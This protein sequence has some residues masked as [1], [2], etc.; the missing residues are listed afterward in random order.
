MASASVP[1]PQQP[2]PSVSSFGRVFG[3]LFN[4]KPTFESIVQQPSWILPMLAVVLISI[5]IVA[6]IGSR[7]G[8]RQVI[9]RQI[10]SSP[11]AQQRME[12]VPAGQREEILD[13]QAKFAGIIAYVGVVLGTVIAEVV[14]A[15][16]LM[17]VFNLMAG[18]KTGFST[19]LGIVA[20]SWMPY[21]V[22]GIL[23]IVIL[24]IK[25][26]STVDIEH[27]VAS[28]P[29]AFLPDTAPKWL[30]SLATSFD[31]FTIW[32]LILQ[33]IGFSAT[34]PK[35]ISVGRAFGIIFAVFLI[36]VL[37]KAGLAAAFS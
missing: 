27:L 35:K 13:K 3:A 33:A 14:A 9:D 30:V 7:V 15:A 29:G 12:Q 1:P 26:P 28:N 22:A 17:G 19:A 37:I 21:F 4:P 8:W 25:D 24:Y 31:I 32:A 2:A 10:A 16:V 23:G 34:N 36:F 18:S 20:H 5:V 11:K 6:L